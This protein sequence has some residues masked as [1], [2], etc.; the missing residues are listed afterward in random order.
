MEKSYK[1]IFHIDLNAFFASCEMAK[2]PIYRDKPI[3]IGGGGNRGVLTTANYVAR[4]F[5]VNSGMS[6]NEAK[7]L[8]PN[9]IILPV[10]FELYHEYSDKFF[11]I[12]SEYA[13]NI[14]RGSID[15]AWLDVTNYEKLH[16]LKLAEM[17]QKR[18][19]EELSLPCS[20]GIAPNRFLAKMASDMKKPLGITVLRKRDVKEKL[21]PLSIRKMYGIGEKSAANLHLLGI[22]TIGDFALYQDKYKLELAL[23]SRSIELQNKANGIDDSRV[24]AHRYDETKSIGISRTYEKDITDDLEIFE[25]LI[26]LAREIVSRMIEDNLLVRTISIQIRCFDF[27]QFS[28]SITLAHHTDNLYDILAVVERLFDESSIIKPVRLLGVTLANLTEK[29]GH[30][31]QLSLFHEIKEKPQKSRINDLVNEINKIYGRQVIKKGVN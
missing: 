26:K 22:K 21:W 15:E 4:K 1:V 28:K 24:D 16:P 18:V 7:R 31:Q 8:C 23:G 3:G 6:V 12:L 20:I 2:N 19:L 27:T 30:F 11:S 9:L 14:E 10:R 5:G 29:K 25:K 17:I 13:D